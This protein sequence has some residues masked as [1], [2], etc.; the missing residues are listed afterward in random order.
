MGMLVGDDSPLCRKLVG[1]CSC[2][3]CLAMEQRKIARARR[4]RFLEADA[5]VERKCGLAVNAFSFDASLDSRERMNHFDA[6][7]RSRCF[8]RTPM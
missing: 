6:V 4:R 5:V 1:A 7:I 3:E 8:A 2:P